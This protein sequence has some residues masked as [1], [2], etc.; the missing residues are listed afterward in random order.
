MAETANLPEQ[1]H[2]RPGTDVARRYGGSDSEHLDAGDILIPRMK[3]AQLISRVVADRIVDFG[4]IY[5]L[6]SRDD[7]E[8]WVLAEA[9]KRGEDV[10]EPV[11]FYLH[12]EP[13]KGWSWR[14]PEKRLGRGPKYPNLGLVLNQDPREVRRTY[15][16]LLT[17]PEYPRLPVRFLMHG[18]WGGQ[19]AKQLNTELVL[20]RQSGRAIHEV[21]F[22]L[23]TKMTSSPQD[24]QE[25]PFVAAIVGVAKVAAKD[26]K[27][28]LEVVQSHIDLVGTSNVS[29]LD[30][31]DVVQPS[32][33]ATEAP[34]LD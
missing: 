5:I 22:T 17:V 1:L 27:A 32:E 16:F 19:S 3:L 7:M 26:R 28:D 30:D 14:D 25:R 23:R 20:T 29:E 15:D 24:G 18:Q 13:R 31:S 4:A 11:R 12:G 10:G 21:P 2:A 34:S 8:P 6:Q 9:P 33:V